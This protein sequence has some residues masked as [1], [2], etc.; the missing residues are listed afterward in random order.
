M[1]D[2]VTGAS[3]QEARGIWWNAA[4]A[5]WYPTKWLAG[6]HRFLGTEHVPRT[7][8]ALVVANHI[9]YLDPIYTGI[10]FDKIGRIPRF[11]AKDAVFRMPLVG[12]LATRLGQIPVYRDSSDAVDSL[13][14]ADRALREGHIVAIYP[15]GTITRDPAFWPMRA[16]T[17]AARLAMDHDVPVIPLAHWGTQRIYDHYNGKRFRPL[18]RTRVIVQAGPPIDLSALRGR[19]KNGD[20]LRQATDHLMTAVRDLLAQVRGET[21]PAEFHP[22]RSDRA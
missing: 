12:P 16:H 20:S 13:R 11:L 1:A 17:G 14:E 19:P 7:G 8:P 3:A 15:E 6:P 4:R 2:S 10:Y 18:P 5:I 9:S 21:P 22:R